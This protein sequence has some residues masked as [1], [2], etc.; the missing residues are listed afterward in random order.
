[1]AKV[2]NLYMY[3]SQQHKPA[4]LCSS[5]VNKNKPAWLEPEL[6]LEAKKHIFCILEILIE[7]ANEVCR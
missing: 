7:Q 3:V 4:F 5:L 6:R 1:M 2:L